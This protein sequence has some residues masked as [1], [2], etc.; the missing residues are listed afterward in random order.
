MRYLSLV[1]TVELDSIF[2]PLSRIHCIRLNMQQLCSLFSQT[3]HVVFVR[4]L[5]DFILFKFIIANNNAWNNRKIIFF[6]SHTCFSFTRNKEHSLIQ[7]YFL[8]PN[9]NVQE[10]IKY[11]KY[12]IEHACMNFYYT[13][14]YFC[15]TIQI[16]SKELNW[17]FIWFC[18]ISLR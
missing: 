14:V 13:N 8:T 3:I 7:K 9:S 1:Q 12:I 2:D 11:W 4:N 17:T 10:I 5:R 6:R 18:N 15:Y 16:Y